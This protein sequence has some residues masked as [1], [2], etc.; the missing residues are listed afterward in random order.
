MTHIKRILIIIILLSAGLAVNQASAACGIDSA[1]IS[2]STQAGSFD[3]SFYSES[4]AQN[5]EVTI[6]VTTHECANKQPVYVSLTQYDTLERPTDSNGFHATQQT[7]DTM[8]D[9]SGNTVSG[10]PNVRILDKKK[11]N[12]STNSF[13]IT[14]HPGED[15]CGIAVGTADCRYSVRVGLSKDTY[16]YFSRNT[17]IGRAHV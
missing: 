10:N 3:N 13:K 8:H 9:V 6:T 16:D 2:P 1:T 7:A 11:I 5:K 17:K 12:F 4:T 14:L 15:L